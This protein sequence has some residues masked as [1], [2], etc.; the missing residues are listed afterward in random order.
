MLIIAPVWP[1]NRYTAPASVPPA[2]S[3]GEVTTTSPVAS[4][5]TDEPNWFPRMRVNKLPKTCCQHSPIFNWPHMHNGRD[6]APNRAY[7]KLPDIV[8][9]LC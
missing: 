8:G 2:S 6:G 1:L 4:G 7:T 5:T 9:A 3:Y